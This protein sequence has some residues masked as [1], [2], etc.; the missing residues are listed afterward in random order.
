MTP[1]QR[2]VL[3]MARD[4]LAALSLELRNQRQAAEIGDKA[5]VR[6]ILRP[7]DHAIGQLKLAESEADR[8]R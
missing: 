3:S 5:G 1:R 2:A 7:L 8:G 4:R 6:R